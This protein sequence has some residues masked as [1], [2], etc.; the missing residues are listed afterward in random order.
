MVPTLNVIG[1]R[2]LMNVGFIPQLF[3]ALLAPFLLRR[4]VLFHV[5]VSLMLVPLFESSLYISTYQPVKLQR[6]A[7]ISMIACGAHQP[8]D[9]YP[10]SLILALFPSGNA[11]PG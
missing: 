2:V 7:L 10:A 1:A 6:I 4:I 5:P 11:S 9:A 8:P 3:A